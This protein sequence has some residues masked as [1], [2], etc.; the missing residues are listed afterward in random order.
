[1]SNHCEK[2][3]EGSAFMYSSERKNKTFWVL[4]KQKKYIS[5][6]IVFLILF[7]SLMKKEKLEA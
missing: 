1:M 5:Q 6:R 2:D 4:Q 3:K 7:L